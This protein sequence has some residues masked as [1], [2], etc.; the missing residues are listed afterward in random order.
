MPR[1]AL[2]CNEGGKEAAVV[3]L[4]MKTNLF[5][6]NSF[7]DDGP[8]VEVDNRVLPPNRIIL[9]DVVGCWD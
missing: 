8:L 3:G 9:V 6:I 1:G 4:A 5:N 7:H 2:G